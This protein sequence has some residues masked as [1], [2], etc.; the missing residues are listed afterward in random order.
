MKIDKRKKYFLVLD[1]ETTGGL[2]NPLVYD[3]GFAV[4]DKK[5]N[6]Y[7]KHSYIIKEI[8]DNKKLMSNAYY[9]NKI[10]SYLQ[11]LKNGTSQKV[12]FE[13]A[14]QTIFETLRKYHIKTLCA[15]NLKFDMNALKST[16]TYLKQEPSK[17]LIREFKT[18]NLL[19]IWSFACEVLYSRPS[20]LSFVEKHNYYTEKGN[21]LTNAE[22]GYRY[23]KSDP[24]FK[25]EHKGLSDVEIECYILYKCIAQSKPHKSG[26]LSNPWKIVKEYRETR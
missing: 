23:L 26:I 25:E 10:P 15:Y 2:D 13:F 5:G 19:C 4:M 20:F 12:D 14:R 11:D 16:I 18:I 9:K 8:F 7:E 22:I 17:F 21:V 3:I 6:I 1:V 24:T